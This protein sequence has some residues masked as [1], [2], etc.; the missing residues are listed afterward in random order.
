MSSPPPRVVVLGGGVAGLEAAVLLET[1]LSGR[2]HLHVVYVDDEFVLRVDGVDADMG[3]V[4]LVNGRQLPYEHLVIATGPG[5]RFMD[6][7]VRAMAGM[8]AE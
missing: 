5:W 1:R 7:G 2:V 8:P 6:L 3:R 4:H